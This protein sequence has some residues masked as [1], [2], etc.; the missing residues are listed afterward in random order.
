TAE[1]GNV[2][3]P[4]WMMD[5][6]GLDPSGSSMVELETVSLSKGQF[7]EFQAHE[8]KFAMLNNPR[9]VLENTLRSYSALTVGDT[10]PVQFAGKTYKLDVTD[11]QPKVNAG[12]NVPYAISI[13]ETDIKVEFKEPRDYKQWEKAQKEKKEESQKQL[14]DSDNKYAVCLF[15]VCLVY[16]Y[17]VNHVKFQTITFGGQEEEEDKD[18]V[19]DA[20]KSDKS[21]YFKE[22]E[23]SGAKGNALKR[24]SSS[25]RK[26][27][28]SNSLSSAASP[29]SPT[30]ANTYSLPSKTRG[31][32]L[33]ASTA[34]PIT[35]G[36]NQKSKTIRKEEEVV[37][38]MRYIYEIDESGNRTCIRKL[39]VRNNLWTASS[40]H[41]LQD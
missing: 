35:A 23:E 17:A 13:I 34:K 36:N 29:A 20:A 18:W 26:N 39:P 14:Q 8:T 24:S 30:G 9:V 19:L 38:N 27:F 12:L 41:K 16:I 31:A 25:L 10:I 6:L 7:V 22:L 33:G 32:P 21:S 15:C 3:L 5:N 37:G 40:G 1:E 11:V 4:L 28:S 2:Y